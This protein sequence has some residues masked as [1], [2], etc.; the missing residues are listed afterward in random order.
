MTPDQPTT[1]GDA[2]TPDAGQKP[3]T[4]PTEGAP[5][6]TVPDQSAPET[7][8]ASTPGAAPEPEPKAK[9]SRSWLAYGAAFLVGAVALVVVAGL[10]ANIFTRKAE[11]ETTV[12]KVVDIEDG[13]TDAS[14]WGQNFPLEYSRFV[15]TEDDTV[16][17]Q[18][19]GSEKY[20]KLARYPAMKRLWNGYAFSVDFNEERGHFYTLIDQKETKRQEVVKQPGACANCHSGDTPNL[21]KSM[22]WE[23]FNKGPYKEIQDSLHTAVTCNDCHDPDTMALRITRP[24]FETAMAER[25]IDLAKASRQEM[26]TYVCAQCHVEYY[27]LGDN[28]ILTFPWEKGLTADNINDYYDEYGF[29]DWEHKETGAPMIKIQ[30]P[31]YELYSTGLHAKSGVSC[32]DCHMPY[33]REG[34]TKVSDHWIRSPMN[35]IAASCQTCHKMDEGKLVERILTAQDRTATQLRQTETAIIALIDAINA[36]K[37]A[38]ATD[39][40]LK[41]ARDYQRKANLRWDFISSENSTGFHSPQEAA[42]VLG[43]AMNY[44]RLGQLSAERLTMSLTGTAPASS[45]LPLDESQVTGDPNPPRLE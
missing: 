26:R 12:V 25:G 33:I 22:G 28:K 23:A 3:T 29:K 7:A 36:A 1:P 5:M 30:H 20:D 41:E 31:E 37:A 6:T 15:M 34:A 17:T 2:M 38:G 42:R 32:A 24:A 16:R 43:D 18:Y 44:A 14:V 11:G 8:P 13:E 19:G 39:D 9:R 45:L 21:I 4:Q 35:N 10:L 40:A 27:F